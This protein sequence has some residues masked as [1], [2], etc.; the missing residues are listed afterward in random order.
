MVCL[1]SFIWF[2][3]GGCWISFGLVRS[4]SVWIK[5]W[6]YINLLVRLTILTLPTTDIFFCIQVK[7]KK[8]NQVET[9]FLFHKSLQGYDFYTKA[10]L[11]KNINTPW[12]S[13]FGVVCSITSYIKKK[14]KDL[15]IIQRTPVWLVVRCV[16]ILTHVLLQLYALAF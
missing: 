9:A 7:K 8:K 13:V 10:L 1:F 12:W 14:K 5:K 16:L 3:S 15:L 2:K 6:N 4:F 11:I